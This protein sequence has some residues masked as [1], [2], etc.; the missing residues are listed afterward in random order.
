MEGVILREPEP[1]GRGGQ[2]SYLGGFKAGQQV[3]GSE[4]SSREGEGELLT[5]GEAKTRSELDGAG[6]GQE[7]RTEQI[8]T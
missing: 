5:N 8:A 1:K 7:N 6:C 2:G 4:Q 3:G